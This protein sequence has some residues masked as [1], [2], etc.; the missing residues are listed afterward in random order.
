ML[1]LHATAQ[2]NQ[3]DLSPRIEIKQHV[4]LVNVELNY[5]QPNRR[6]RTIFGSLIPFGKVW[7]TGANMSTKITFDKEVKLA[8]HI[9]PKGNYALYTIPEQNEWTIIIH[10]N[11][12]LWGTNGY[13]KESDLVRFNVPVINLTD[14]IETL[15]IN[16]D[17]FTAD[18][19]DLIILW[20]NTKVKIP[21]YVNSEEVILK[22]ILEKTAD[23]NKKISAQTYYDAAKFYVLKEKDLNTAMLWFTKAIELKPN[24]FWIVYRKAELALELKDYKL[25]K[26]M[27]EQCNTMAKESTSDYGYI[28]KSEQLL[29]LISEQK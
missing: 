2:I 27:A 16:F 12:S 6:S 29:N 14:T 23:S 3:P 8:N 28:L 18:G 15:S 10:K 21:L 13:D 4:G 17:N 24:A 9:I 20:E 26:Q 5:G 19:G 25:A 7:R 1:T 22:E 11:D